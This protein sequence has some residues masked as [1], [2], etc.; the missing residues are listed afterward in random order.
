[1]SNHHETAAT[2]PTPQG[3]ASQPESPCQVPCNL[4]GSSRVEVAR[5]KGRHGIALRSVIC[6]DC[7]LVWTDPR[8]SPEDERLFYSQD[9]RL[10]YKGVE[11]PKLKHVRRSGLAAID[12]WR[13]ICHLVPPCAEV[14]DVGAGG[15]E[16]LYMG[17]RLGHRV[18]G[19]EPND[20]YARYA[21]EALGLPIQTGFY[22]DMQVDPSS[23]DLLTLF[24]VVEHLE[25]PLDA[26]STCAAWLKPGGFLV[27]EVP[28]VEATC[29]HPASQFHRGHLYH[30]NADN[31]GHLMRKAG[32]TPHSCW[33]SG[34]AGNVALVGMRP[35]ACPAQAA[36]PGEQPPAWALPGNFLKVRQVLNRHTSLVHML[37]P[38]PYLRPARK[39][40]IRV[41][42]WRDTRHLTDGRQL[43]D[44]LFEQHLA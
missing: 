17:R 9:Y 21:R 5:R 8:P 19:V 40:L 43:L 14:M 1:M 25:N 29:Q 44:R 33:L 42:E 12:R 26:I 15:G 20:G 32:L 22:Q 3:T 7:G 13:H 31:L 39:L 41:G 34:D 16:F 30:F 36:T 23:L 38:A 27:I 2:P 18:R 11:Q 6:I 24:H 35:A 37:K 4:C 28:N 10:T